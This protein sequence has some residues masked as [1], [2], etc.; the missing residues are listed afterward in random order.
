MNLYAATVLAGEQRLCCLFIWIIRL[1]YSLAS[2]S[3]SCNVR[4]CKFG[5]P[6]LSCPAISVNPLCTV[7][8]AGSHARSHSQTNI[9]EKQTVSLGRLAHDDR[10]R[11]ITLPF[12]IAYRC[13]GLPVQRQCSR[14]NHLCGKSM[15]DRSTAPPAAMK[16]ASSLSQKQLLE[17]MKGL[18]LPIFRVTVPQNC[19]ETKRLSLHIKSKIRGFLSFGKL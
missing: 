6:S 11:A 19:Q 4:P 5:S 2:F 13:I 17:A 10:R 3:L 14:R 9:N 15:M 16:H 12:T 7:R 8:G 1:I 18:F